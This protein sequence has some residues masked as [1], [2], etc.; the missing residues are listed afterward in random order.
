MKYGVIVNYNTMSLKSRTAPSGY[1]KEQMNSRIDQLTKGLLS[2]AVILMFTA[3][4]VAGQARANLPADAKAAA[5]FGGT[6]RI[7]II[8]DTE[9]LR[10]IDASLHIVDKILALPIDIEFSINELRIRT[11]NAA[12]GG[13]DDA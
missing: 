4:L 11:G 7:G 12:A 5:D 3:A 1:R 9:S 10:K 13:P 6:T 2:L 8:L